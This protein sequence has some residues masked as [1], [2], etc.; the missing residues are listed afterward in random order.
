[1]FT[2]FYIWI[3]ILI[4]TA[5]S[6]TDYKVIFYHF[7]LDDNYIATIQVGNRSCTLTWVRFSGLCCAVLC[8]I[9]IRDRFKQLG[10]NAIRIKKN[11][12]KE[13][14][15]L[16]WKYWSARNRFEA[17]VIAKSLQIILK[18]SYFA[19]FLIAIQS[20]ICGCKNQKPSN[21]RFTAPLTGFPLEL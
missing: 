2:P 3:N 5:F 17:A 13:Q 4:Y 9:N 11:R 14:T 8:I 21:I 12:N 1:M 7:T 20:Y 18:V 6:C 10:W 15:T 16:S 19:L